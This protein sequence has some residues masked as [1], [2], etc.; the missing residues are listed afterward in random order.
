MSEPEEEKKIRSFLGLCTYYRRF[1]SEFANI[2]KPPTK[3]TEKM[4]AFQ[5]TPE[6]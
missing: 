1:I 4:Q 3:L 6:V 5:W 2:A